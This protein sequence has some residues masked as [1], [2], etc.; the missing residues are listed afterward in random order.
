VFRRCGLLS[1]ERAVARAM[2]GA[3]VVVGLGML[4]PHTMFWGE[5][6][7]ATIATMAPASALPHVWPTSGLLSFEINSVGTAL[8]VGVTK[9]VAISFTVCGGY[10]GGYIFPAFAAGAALGRAI[11]ML[12][13][14]SLIP[15]QLC[16]L[17]MAASLNV[18]LTRT[19]ISTTL[20]LVFLSGEQNAMAPVLAAA[21]VSLFVTSYMTFIPSQIGRHDMEE[22]SVYHSDDAPLVDDAASLRSGRTN[23]SRSSGSGEGQQKYGM[24]LNR[25]V[26][27]D[28]EHGPGGCVND[29]DDLLDTPF[30]CVSRKAYPKTELETLAM[31]SVWAKVMT[32]R[33]LS[34]VSFFTIVIIT[35]DSS[36]LT[37]WFHVDY[38]FDV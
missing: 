23:R 28:D 30:A 2:A 6:E 25:V 22:S 8:V 16:V 1:S 15:L 18:A 4:V 9:L 29:D 31:S 7:F 38:A 34:V 11:Y 36:V 32:F 26:E 14:P 13:G 20:I 21:L 24:L 19:A 35:T 17:C 12:C 5:F 10:R 33:I 3:V 37:C 27:V